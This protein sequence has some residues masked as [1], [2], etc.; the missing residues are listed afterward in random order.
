MERLI[1]LSNKYFSN[2]DTGKPRFEEIIKPINKEDIIQVT[3]KSL[4]DK[5]YDARF[6]NKKIS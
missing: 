2:F 3:R 4:V 1:Q 6:Q 5:L